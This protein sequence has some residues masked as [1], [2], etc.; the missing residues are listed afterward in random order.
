M[1]T[2]R[3]VTIRKDEKTFSVYKLVS[4][5]K[6][7]SVFIAPLSTQDGSYDEGKFEELYRTNNRVIDTQTA[8]N[9]ERIFPLNSIA[10]KFKN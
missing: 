9:L 3:Q 5:N 10:Q 1:A 7:L 6:G 8:R 4:S 2:Q